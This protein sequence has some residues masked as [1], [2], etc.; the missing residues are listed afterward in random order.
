MICN[1]IE[2]YFAEHV[3]IRVVDRQRAEGILHTLVEFFGQYKP[4][5]LTARHFKDYC[6]SR[7]V[8]NSTLRRE[9][10]VLRAVFNH[11][12]RQRRISADTLPYMAL[13]P[14]S[15]PK[16][17][18]LTNDELGTLWTAA[19]QRTRDFIDLAYYTAGRKAS[20]ERL[21]EAQVD[22]A[23]NRINLA[24]PG[25]VK[26][27]KRRPIVPI[28]KEL[29]PTVERCLLNTSEYLLGEPSPV[30]YPFRKAVNA[31]GLDAVTPHTLRHTRATHLLQEGADPFAVAQL[32]GDTMDTVMRV[33]GHHCPNYLAGVLDRNS[34]GFR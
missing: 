8:S 29:R 10:T 34:K 24:K 20:I 33:Y 23:S 31:A 16:D 27:K 18:W 19:D 32:L 12:H 28:D 2:D 30:D 5:D 26:T 6:K 22:L 25:E 11:A 21:T 15:E 9:L 17:R 3:E 13:P 4:D 7:Q 14:E 1:L